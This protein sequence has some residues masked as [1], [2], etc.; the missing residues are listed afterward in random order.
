[1]TK[2]IIYSKPPVL[3]CNKRPS[4]L[5]FDWVLS[6]MTRESYY[7]ADGLGGRTCHCRRKQTSVFQCLA[8]LAFDE[9]EGVQISM[10]LDSLLHQITCVRGTSIKTNLKAMLRSQCRAVGPG[11][12]SYLGSLFTGG[13]ISQAPDLSTFYEEPQT[14]Y[15][16]VMTYPLLRR[17]RHCFGI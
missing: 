2:Y 11:N 9:I 14:L 4:V 12:P 6:V 1:M 8:W 15:L 13:L 10:G 3:C 16:W 17:I 5:W 7:M